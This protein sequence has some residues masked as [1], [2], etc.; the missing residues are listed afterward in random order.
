MRVFLRGI[1]ESLVIDNEWEVTVLEIQ[2]DHVRLGIASP[3]EIPPYREETIFLQDPDIDSDL[4][5]IE[6]LNP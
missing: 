3:H 2:H 4:E 5:L 1:Q 6:S